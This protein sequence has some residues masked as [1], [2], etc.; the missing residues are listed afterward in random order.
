MVMRINHARSSLRSVASSLRGTCVEG[1]EGS[2]RR[3]TEYSATV[4]SMLQSKNVVSLGTFLCDKL[5]L[6]EGINVRVAS[7][8]P[9]V[10]VPDLFSKVNRFSTH[11]RHV[12]TEDHFPVMLEGA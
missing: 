7:Q 4:D 11:L 9:V 10:D 8:V 1:R 6:L 3:V 12:F 5:Q 2:S